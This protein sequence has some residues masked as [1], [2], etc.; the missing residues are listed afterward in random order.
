VSEF[1]LGDLKRYAN[2]F[3]SYRNVSVW[4]PPEVLKQPKKLQDP[5]KSMDVYSF[6]VIMWELFH[7]CVPFDGDLKACTEYVIQED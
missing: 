7:E 3:Y 1:E 6:G 5:I 2:M 4:S